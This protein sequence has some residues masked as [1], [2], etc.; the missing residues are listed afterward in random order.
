MSEFDSSKLTP[1]QLPMDESTYGSYLK[2]LKGLRMSD[3]K[4]RI[5]NDAFIVSDETGIDRVIIGFLKDA[6]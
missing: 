4:V 3:G 1:N 2:N 6:F 5:E